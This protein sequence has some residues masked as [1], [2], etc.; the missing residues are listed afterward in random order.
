VFCITITIVSGMEGQL[1]QLDQLQALLAQFQAV[2]LEFGIRILIAIAL[3]LIGRWGANFLRRLVRKGMTKA[4]V[5]TTLVAFAS[6]MAYYVVMA[7]IALAILGQFGIETTSLI[8]LIGAAGLAVGLALQGSLSNFA[9]GILIILFRPFHVGDWIEAN[10]VSGIV[11][12]IELLTT[13][14]R[15]LDNRTVVIPNSKLTDD[16]IVNYSTKGIL[17][18]DLVVGVA[19]H[20]NLKHAREVISQ[21]LKEDS[22]ILTDPTPTIGVLELADSSIN[23]A[24]RPW[25]RV[26]NFWPVYFS[27]YEA[28][29]TRFDELGIVIPFPQRDI[30]IQSA[31]SEPL[32]S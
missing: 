4:R 13:V 8:A 25:T 28:I 9:A 31:P 22:R 10:G 19:Y 1:Q 26:E 3:F 11:E 5:D 21:A 6:N 15:T 20:T 24:V 23:L 17:R 30:H 16:N 27:A 12:D 29:K 2:G 18:V 7:F 32:R 14:L